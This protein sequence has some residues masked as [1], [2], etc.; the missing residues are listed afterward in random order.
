MLRRWVYGPGVRSLGREY[1]TKISLR[2]RWSLLVHLVMCSMSNELQ[3]S[4]VGKASPLW[5]RHGV[6]NLML[7]RWALDSLGVTNA[8]PATSA[9]CQ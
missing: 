1:I 9:A 5:T 6:C 4:Q 8:A 2:G 7:V 3:L